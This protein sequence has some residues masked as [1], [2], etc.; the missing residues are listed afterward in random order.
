MNKGNKDGEEKGEEEGRILER[1]FIVDQPMTTIG[2]PLRRK[3][4]TK[5]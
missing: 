2:F 4:Q 3:D 5:D 1:H